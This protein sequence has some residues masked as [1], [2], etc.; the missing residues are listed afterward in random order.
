MFGK[1]IATAL[2][3]LAA[4]CG[5]A[6]KEAPA[7]PLDAGSRVAP[8]EYRSSFADYQRYAEPEAA[9][10]RE[11]NDEVGRLGGHRGALGGRR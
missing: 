8:V 3:A 9:S 4:G 5:G 1:A 6:P 2:A 10:W 7:G 11:L